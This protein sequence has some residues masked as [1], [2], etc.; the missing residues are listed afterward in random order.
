M[1]NA[2]RIQFVFKGSKRMITEIRGRKLKPLFSSDEILKR[3][4]ELGAQ[5][6]EDY[7]GKN[8]VLIGVLKGA[9][10]FLADLVRSIDFHVELDFIRISSYKNG[11][12]PGDIEL[13]MDTSIPLR[14]RHVILFED[15]LDTGVT[16]KFIKDKILSREPAS[17]KICVLID[18]KERRQFHINA[19]YVGF[20]INEGFIVGYGIDWGE[21]GRNI[22]GIYV[23]E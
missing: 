13:I 19:D 15:I 8:P 6:T 23:V 2:I 22:P 14:D 18:K 7:T 4:A 5:I 11:M 20:E 10:I 9:F 17:F 3:V 16:L 21:Q 12:E 1:W